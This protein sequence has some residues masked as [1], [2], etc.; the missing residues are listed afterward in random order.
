MFREHFI[1]ILKRS[2]LLYDANA[3]L[4]AS[5]TRRALVRL[6][7]RYE[8]LARE[9]GIVY[10]EVA[11]LDLLRERLKRRGLDVAP[12]TKGGL[13]ILWTGANWFQDSSGFLAGLE[14]MGAVQLFHHAPGKYGLRQTGDGDVPVN[15]LAMS[16]YIDASETGPAFDLVM[17]Q[18]WANF[19]SAGALDR[20]RERGIVTINVS[21]D[22]RLPE[23][24]RSKG[25]LRLGSVGLGPGLDMV[26]TSSPECCERYLVENCPALF[27][28]MASDP[29]RFKPY[30]ESEKKYDVSF[31][32]SKY[33]LRGRIVE[34][35]EHAGVHVETFGPG[36]PN[37][38]IDASRS[39]EVFGRSR[40]I[41]GI[42]TIAHND[43]LFTLKLRD[44]DA[45][46]A[47]ALY[48]T[49]RNP[50]L[51]TL[52]SEGKEIVCYESIEECVHKVKYYLA[53]PAHRMAIAASGMARAH[54]EHTWE[55]RIGKTLARMG[56]LAQDT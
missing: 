55:Q 10:S 43:D 20:V 33:G 44:F 29:L 31:V 46:T 30:P 53:H 18:M 38:S 9:R 5:Q 35:L 3:R 23:H 50:D 19:I 11:A 34:A 12:K 13:R 41:L 8:R 2:A 14:Q 54:R 15:D 1:P 36:W 48:L 17:G 28:P 21:M 49:H 25:G 40:I 45:T 47:G 27:F 7:R 22:D 56:L 52:F 16:K 42:G 24:W 39:A 6:K 26:L 37:G 4:K 32:G 51:L